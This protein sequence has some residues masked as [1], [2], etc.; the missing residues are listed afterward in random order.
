MGTGGRPYEGQ[1]AVGFR[2]LLAEWHLGLVGVFRFRSRST[3]VFSVLRG[4]V[5]SFPCFAASH[6]RWLAMWKV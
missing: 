5:R 4:P 3:W 1:A 2:C 6:R